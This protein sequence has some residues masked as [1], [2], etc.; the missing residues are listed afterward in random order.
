MRFPT[1]IIV[2]LFVALCIAACR[3]P[4]ELRHE[5]SADVETQAGSAVDSLA[6]Q[7][8][9]QDTVQT[10]P[11][12]NAVEADSAAHDPAADLQKDSVAADSVADVQPADSA[13]SRRRVQS[14]SLTADSLQAA[15]DSVPSD[16]VPKRKAGID[17]PVEYQAT[18]SMVYDAQTGLALLYGSAKVNYLDMQL[19][20]E[21]IAMN[22]DSSLVHAQ[23]RPDSTQAGGWKGKPVY[24]QGQDQYDSERMSFNFKTKKGFIQNVATTQGNGYLQSRNS[25]R[26]DDGTLF[27]QHAKYTTCDAA[28]PHFYI[29]LSRA[30]VRPGKES[31]FGPAY[32]VVEDVPL[33]LAIPY[34][35]FPFNKK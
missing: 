16:T 4:F 12:Q 29:S 8:A 18:D 7:Q 15:T 11:A 23:G 5:P 28:H 20:A 32:L 6:G 22:M 34:G 31:V 21:H 13:R 30:K 14:G 3:S 27:L 25:K 19:E 1:F 17:S 10:A 2:L 33:P 35:F 9:V 24:K 26:T